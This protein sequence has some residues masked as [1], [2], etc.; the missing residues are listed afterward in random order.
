MPPATA[1]LPGLDIGKD[2]PQR[3]DYLLPGVLR[4]RL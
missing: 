3:L 1:Q 2:L 4:C